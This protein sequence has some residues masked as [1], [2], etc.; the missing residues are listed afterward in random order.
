MGLLMSPL[1][2]ANAFGASLLAD[3]LSNAA[4]DD[5]A[6][7]STGIQVRYGEVKADRHDDGDSP[8]GTSWARGD[9]SGVFECNSMLGEFD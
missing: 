4:V 3:F 9:A 5:I 1:R 8:D 7:A 2:I 6:K